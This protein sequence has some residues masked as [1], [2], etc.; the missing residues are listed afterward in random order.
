MPTYDTGCD[1]AI[2]ALNAS[3][4]GAGYLS[5]EPHPHGLAARVA[6][7]HAEAERALTEGNLDAAIG[8]DQLARALT[9]VLLSEDD[10]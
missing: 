10:G 5:R 1:L 6:D 2:E 3:H 7:A 4:A 8:A 9:D